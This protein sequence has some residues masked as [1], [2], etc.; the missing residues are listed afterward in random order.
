MSNRDTKEVYRIIEV[1]LMNMN[2][3]INS[4]ETEKLSAQICLNYLRRNKEW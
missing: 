1:F 4:T 2:A 3:N